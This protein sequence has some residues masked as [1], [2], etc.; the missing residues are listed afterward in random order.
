[1]FILLFSCSVLIIQWFVLKDNNSTRRIEGRKE[2]I[3]RF[4]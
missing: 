2:K 3:V 1:V 4:F